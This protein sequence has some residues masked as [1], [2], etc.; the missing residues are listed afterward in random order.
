MLLALFGWACSTAPSYEIIIENG[1]VVD[2][3]GNPAYPADIAI[4]GGKIAKIGDLKDDS[5]TVRLDASDLVVAPGFIDLHSHADRGLMD[6][7]LKENKGFIT[8]GVTT[9]VFGIDGSYTPSV[10]ERIIVTFEKQGVGTNY[11]FYVGHN[12][13]RREVMG[14]EDRAPTFE[15]LDQMKALVREAMEHGA[16][17]LSSGLMYLPGRYADTE[18]VIELAKIAAE[19][20]GAYDSHVRDPAKDL[21]ASVKE[22][23]EIGE[24]SGARPH[25]AHHKAPGQKNWGKSKE[26]AELI[27]GALDRGVQV[28]VDQY[29]YDGAATSKLIRVLV[30][31][32]ELEVAKTMERRRERDLGEE[33]RRALQNQ[34]EEEIVGALQDPQQKAR[35]QRA[36]EEG[37]PGVYSWVQTVGYDSFRIVVSDKHPEYVGML[38]TE[39]AAQE[40][41]D[42][43]SLVARLVIEER[44]AVKIT[45][46]ACSEDD[47]RDIMTRP[48]TMIASDGGITGFEEGGGHPRS[49][50]TFTR[51]LGRYVREWNVLSL[52]EAV[53]KMTSMSAAFLKLP[54]RG[55]LR[56]NYWAD[57][58]VFNPE[59]VIDR[60][61]WKEP[62]LFSEGIVHVLVNG[63]LALENGKMTGETSGAF[64]RFSGKGN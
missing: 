3:T 43:F 21:I 16:F 20:G 42:P 33:E 62:A 51:V 59:T 55:I 46:G 25:P 40:G 18:E 23:I 57:I 15:E 41:V 39:A 52:E 19:Y 32:P 10:I 56:E 6:P 61:T 30:V 37:L 28:T 5:A 38:V 31:P 13:V 47:V 45:L 54:D 11:A 64:L 9:C 26:I 1:T 14:M 12:G 48:W 22:C 58:T 4:S 44:S 7:E 34:I 50:G 63:R 60:S 2:G 53:K 29:P 49:R 35:I 24:K 8:Q 27:Q 17:G 36:T